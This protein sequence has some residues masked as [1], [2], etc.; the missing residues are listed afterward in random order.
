MKCN[1]CEAELEEG[2]TLCPECGCENGAAEEETVTAEPEILEE[3]SAA[4]DS[5][6]EPTPIVEGKLTPG[7]I[8]LLV[9]LAVAAVAV[10]VALIMGGLSGGNDTTE[11]TEATVLESVDAATEASEA[12]EAT[13]PADGNPD[14]VTCKGSYTASDDEV[15]AARET[16]VATLGDAVLTN[17]ELQIHYWMQFYDFLNAYGGYASMLGLD[18]TKPLDTQ[19]SPDGTLTWQQ[20]M[21]DG[22]LNAWHSYEALAMDAEKA[23]FQ[24]EQAYVDFLSTLR[25][26]MDQQAQT[27]G[28]ASA[29]EMLEAD[30][31]PGCTMDD[32]VLYMEDYY[33]GYLYYLSLVEK[34]EVTADEVEAYYDENAAT[35]AENGVEK[36]DQKYVDV[37]HILILP[38]GGTTAEDGT[39]T[40][41]DDEW[42]T[43]RAAA[44]AIL[45]QWLAG[46]ATEDSFAQLANTSSEDPGSNTNGGLYEDVYVGQMV[47]PFEEWCF[48][49]SRQYGDTGLV[50][51]NYGYHVMYF[52]GS[53]NVWYANAKS[54][55]LSNM[56]AD[57]LADAMDNYELNIDYS[58]IRLGFVDFGTTE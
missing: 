8:A 19:L 20:Y 24:L 38:Q 21:L 15:R 31:G 44:Q 25:E 12:T 9:V 58:A 28:F 45:D 23:G 40:Y 17:G 22:G 49:E 39:T 2:I 42:E 48:D 14:D 36:D 7:K 11:P 10:V 33:M 5:E 57:I 35:F 43:C 26:T 3:P 34:L 50:Q 51:T 29:Q 53:E 47:E 55:L 1:N 6:A 18:Y 30:M 46:E 13:I 56:Q 54:E 27:A 32:Y 4:E 41:S 52:V 37:R 16:V